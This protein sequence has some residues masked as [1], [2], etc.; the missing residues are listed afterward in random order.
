M[1]EKQI[2]E[3]IDSQFNTVTKI[4]ED[5]DLAGADVMGES[6]ALPAGPDG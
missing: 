3:A 1:S 2:E 4:G 5:L 6:C